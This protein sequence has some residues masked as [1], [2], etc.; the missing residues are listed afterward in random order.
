VQISGEMGEL[1][2]E[3]ELIADV[4]IDEIQSRL[5]QSVSN[6][7]GLRPTIKIVEHNVLPR[8]EAK[9][10]RFFVNK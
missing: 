10:Q 2:L 6:K 9:G 5:S 7:L 4:S 1:T 3:I 8:F